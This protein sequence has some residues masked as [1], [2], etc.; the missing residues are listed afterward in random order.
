[1][2][3]NPNIKRLSILLDT[4]MHKQ[5]KQASV[6]YDKSMNSIVIEALH[7]KLEKIDTRK[8]KV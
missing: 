2:S 4:K 8:I 6:D 5:L 1:M 3:A 7:E